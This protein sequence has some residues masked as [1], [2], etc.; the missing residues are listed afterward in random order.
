MDLALQT[1]VLGVK[2]LH[3]MG[4]TVHIYSCDTDVLVLALRR[5]P[6]RKPNSDHH[7]YWRST[8]TNQTQAHLRC[9]I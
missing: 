3:N 6:D 7:G 5:V 8:T 9:S 2:T 1:S 4:N